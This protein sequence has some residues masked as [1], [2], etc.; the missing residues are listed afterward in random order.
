MKLC[1]QANILIIVSTLTVLAS[2][3]LGGK[4]HA[5]GTLASV[6]ALLAYVIN[7]LCESG[8]KTAAWIG[9]FV[10]TVIYFA[11]FM[12][13]LSIGFKKLKGEDKKDDEDEKDDKKKKKDDKKKKK[14]EDDED[15]EDEDEDDDG[16]KKKEPKPSTPEKEAFA[17]Y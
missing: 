15:D 14:D 16:E 9:M 10:P 11:L 5:I 17:P 3:L 2:M 8:N 4:V 1:L 7:M 12:I 13:L 6:A